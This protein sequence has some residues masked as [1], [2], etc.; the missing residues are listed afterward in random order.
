[1]APH[2]AATKAAHAELAAG[3]GELRR[4]SRAME[5]AHAQDR[6]YYERRVRWMGIAVVVITTVVGA[7]I[8]TS[9]AT[10]TNTAEKAVFGSLSLVAAVI[11]ALNEK[12][13]WGDQRKAHLDSARAFCEVH[14]KAVDLGLNLEVGFVSRDDAREQLLELEKTYDEL[15]DKAPDVRHYDRAYAWVEADER[16]HG[17]MK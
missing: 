1:M 9:L 7:G 10:S 13:P 6:E 3:I 17:R 14:R 12:G 16:A 5:A 11:A 15:K 8:V 2:V 4:G